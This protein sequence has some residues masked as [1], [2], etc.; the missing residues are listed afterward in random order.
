[1]E[2]TRK[3]PNDHGGDK[4]MVIKVGGGGGGGGIGAV[5]LLG[6]ALATAA[7]ASAFAVRFKRRSSG[8]DSSREINEKSEDD[9]MRFV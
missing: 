7:L 6:G 2:E 5:V 1:M 3:S 8:E 4:K 9:I